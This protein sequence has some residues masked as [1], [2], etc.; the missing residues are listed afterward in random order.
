[1]ELVDGEGLADRNRTAGETLGQRLTD[2][3][4]TCSAGSAALVFML[5]RVNVG[6]AFAVRSVLEAA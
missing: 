3:D 2:C 6:V 1:M 5:I 4:A